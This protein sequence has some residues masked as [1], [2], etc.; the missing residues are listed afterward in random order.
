[1]WRHTRETTGDRKAVREGGR[2]GADSR[3]YPTGARIQTSEAKKFPAGIWPR[4]KW[5]KAT[6]VRRASAWIRCKQW[7]RARRA[8]SHFYQALWA[9]F[10]LTT[11]KNWF[12]KTEGKHLS[13]T[14]F[15]FHQ[16]SYTSHEIGKASFQIPWRYGQAVKFWG[17][18]RVHSEIKFIHLSLVTPHVQIPSHKNATTRLQNDFFSCLTS[19]KSL[20]A[21]VYECHRKKNYN[22]FYGSQKR[23]SPS[24]LSY[25]QEQF[26]L[27][28]TFITN[29]S[30]SPFAFTKCVGLQAWCTQ[31]I[32]PL[33]R[34]SPN[35]I[36]KTPIKII[37][38]AQ[39]FDPCE[40]KHRSSRSYFRK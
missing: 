24:Y 37:D 2:E 18:R 39:F 38:T 20:T 25:E 9:T 19:F 35:E 29:D 5:F 10:K 31:T 40:S 17:L 28:K 15:S 6:L 11:E 36:T 33:Q 1:M 30:S 13:G 32:S 8:R 23:T 26:T 22:L 34:S 14:D 16:S 4:S 7:R 12:A 3:V 27:T 21:T